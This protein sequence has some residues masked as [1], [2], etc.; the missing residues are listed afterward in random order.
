MNFKTKISRAKTFIVENILHTPERELTGLWRNL[1]KLVSVIRITAKHFLDDELQL[2][3]SALTYNTMLA[4]VPILAILIAIAGGFGFEKIIESQILESFPAQR[5]ALST[6]FQ[7]V[8]NYLRFSRSGVVIGIGVVFLLW[9]VISL[10]SNIEMTMNKIWQA[11]ERSLYHKINDYTSLFIILPILMILSSGTSVLITTFLK[12]A[13]EMFGFITPL[14]YKL[15]ELS[16]YFFTIIFFTV[17]YL[18]IPNTK[19]KFKYAFIAGILCGIAFQLFQYLYLNGQIWVSKYNAIYGSFAFLP[20]LLLWMQ[21]SWLIFLFGVLLSFSMQTADYGNEDNV[22][23]ISSQYYKFIL[24]IISC[25]IVQRFEK[26]LSPLT[27]QN[28]SSSYNIPIRIAKTI[29]NK[30]IDSGIIIETLNE[31]ERVPSYQPAFDISKMSVGMLLS[32]VDADGTG[33]KNFRINRNE[34]YKLQWDTIT[35]A[36]NTMYNAMDNILIKDVEIEQITK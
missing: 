2:R 9:T 15:L 22:K 10:L 16:P 33:E 36:Y 7:F 25:V 5:D 35:K 1:R 31:D 32:R 34:K 17:A 13:E 27:L 3:A 24:L 26:G 29:I 8:D 11:K 20:L 18:L 14:I 6:A 12:D 21:L 28:I 19:V 30:L 23:K 4:I